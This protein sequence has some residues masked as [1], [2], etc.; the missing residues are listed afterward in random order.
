[1][2]VTQ[3]NDGRQRNATCRQKSICWQ[4]YVNAAVEINMLDYNVA[5]YVVWTGF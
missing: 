3:R 2:E 5:R 4:V 1:M